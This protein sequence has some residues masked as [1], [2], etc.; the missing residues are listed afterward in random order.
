MGVLAINP[1]PDWKG[2]VAVAVRQWSRKAEP[3]KAGKMPS[4][5][6]LPTSF[7]RKLAVFLLLTF[8]APPWRCLFAVGKNAAESGRRVA[9]DTV[10]K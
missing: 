2:G 3:W 10:E 6:F 8:D 1:S 4:V 7:L 9:T 5:A